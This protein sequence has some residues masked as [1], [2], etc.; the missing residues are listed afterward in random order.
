MLVPVSGVATAVVD[1]PNWATLKS[2]AAG[3]RTVGWVTQNWA[4][5]HLPTH[6]DSFF[7]IMEVDYH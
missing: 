2:P 3:Q 1:P 5:F 4:T 6:G 7:F